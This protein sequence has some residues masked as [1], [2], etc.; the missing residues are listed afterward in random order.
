[1]TL[2]RRLLLYAVG[3]LLGVLAVGMFFPGYNWLG[4]L[5]SNAIKTNINK[6]P[7]ELSLHASCKIDCA[8]VPQEHLLDIIRDGKV[9]YD[10]SETKV[11]PRRYHIELEKE[12]VYITL[13]EK[14]SVIEKYSNGSSSET[15]NCP[16]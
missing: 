8:Q 2:K 1:M 15:C 13:D 7:I 16:L 6:F 3:L 9:V 11:K 14:K 12:F 5:P 4:W 10:K